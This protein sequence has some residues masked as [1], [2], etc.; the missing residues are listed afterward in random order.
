MLVTRL[1]KCTVEGVQFAIREGHDLQIVN[2][3][4]VSAEDILSVDRHGH[5]G[6]CNGCGRRCQSEGKCTNP[7]GWDRNFQRR[8]VR[9][10]DGL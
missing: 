3:R 4:Q 9:W 5:E 1:H 10:S 6:A 8:G 7:L 2:I